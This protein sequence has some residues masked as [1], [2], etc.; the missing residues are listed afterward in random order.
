MKK[1]KRT[2]MPYD[3][4]TKLWLATTIILTGVIVLGTMYFKR[5]VESSCKTSPHVL[6]I[7]GEIYQCKPMFISRTGIPRL[8]MEF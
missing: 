8:P 6:V 4:S 2:I 5:Y 7:Q 3:R 1:V